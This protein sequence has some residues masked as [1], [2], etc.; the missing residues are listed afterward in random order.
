M[1]DVVHKNPE[2]G[3]LSQYTVFAVLRDEHQPCSRKWFLVWD[4]QWMELNAENCAPV[5]RRGAQM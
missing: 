2:T 4:G 5:T 3:K 1:F